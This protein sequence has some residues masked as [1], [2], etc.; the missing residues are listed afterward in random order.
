ME[1]SPQTPT[2]R[3]ARSSRRRGPPVLETR[4]WI[5]TPQLLDA[6]H[7]E[8]VAETLGVVDA[9]EVEDED[10]V[11]VLGGLRRGGGPE[12][13]HGRCREDRRVDRRV[14]LHGVDD[15]IELLGRRYPEARAQR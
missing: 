13:A 15:R 8:R 10:P 4:A 2:P 1:S 6:A 3:P 12:I 14:V 7:V 11:G 9:P 5:T